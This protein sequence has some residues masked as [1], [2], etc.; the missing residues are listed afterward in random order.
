MNSHGDV[1]YCCNNSIYRAESLLGN[2]DFNPAGLEIVPSKYYVLNKK[3]KPE[4][5]NDY[6]YDKK[7]VFRVL[8]VLAPAIECLLHHAKSTGRNIELSNPAV[9]NFDSIKLIKENFLI[10]PPLVDDI[11]LEPDSVKLSIENAPNDE[12]NYFV[13]FQEEPDEFE[14]SEQMYDAFAK[15]R[16]T[17]VISGK[18]LKINLSAIDKEEVN[19]QFCVAVVDDDGKND[20]DDLKEEEPEII[21]C[22]TCAKNKSVPDYQIR[23]EKM[24]EKSRPRLRLTQAHR[25]IE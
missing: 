16:I 9:I 2:P 5:F 6:L 18:L 4:Y 11:L 19:P 25:P 14:I 15:A 12:K 24:E 10:S 23:R 21:P 20:D 1:S 13:K 22:N 8:Q 17:A 7:V 3:N